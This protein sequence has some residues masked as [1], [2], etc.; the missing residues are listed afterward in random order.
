M[1]YKTMQEVVDSMKGIAEI[2]DKRVRVLNET[3]VRTDLI[4]K[5]VFNAV[6]NKDTELRNKIRWL[7][8]AI[9]H[10]LDA[11][12]ASIQ[13]LYD[14]MGRGEA[15]GFTVPAINIRGLTYDVARAV[16][17][18]AK[19]NNSG[20]FIFEIA[21]SE[22][23][24]TEQPPDEYAVV[25]IAA[26]VKEGYKGPV[27]IQGDH[28]QA[29]AKKYQ[30]DPAKEV[31]GL[32]ALIKEAIA[33]GFYNIDI[34][35]STLVD[36]S[37]PD[38]K[39]QQRLNFEIAAELTAYIRQLE[40]KGVTISVGGEIGEVGG[41]NSTV[42]ELRAFMNGYREAMAARGKSLQGISK[43]SVQTGTT[44]GGVPLPDGT[45]AKVKLDFDTLEKI[46]TAARQEYGLSGAVQHGASTLPDDAFH[47]FPETG[48]AE[49]HLATG[50]QN[51]TYDSKIFPADF[52]EDIYSHL[53]E[54]CADEKKQ[55]E[56]DEQF[57]YKT[58]KK[59]F[60][61]FKERF[62]TLPGPVKKTI[63]QELEDKLDFLFRKLKVVNTY[64][65]VTKYVTPAEEYPK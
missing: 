36:L 43:I 35:T 26:A 37:K 33:A 40:P 16:I 9:A 10:E 52:R 6:F 45:I 60:G 54:K 7:I 58:R 39:E 20:A 31:A 46:S 4:D 18:A 50:F 59:G 47:R 13:G 30:Q 65:I 14:A 38:T 57:I 34:D 5:L 53:R 62:W 21:K 12:S 11:I 29:N 61:P 28:F 49:V 1:S 22:I 42:G 51:M 56:S 24:Y 27:F 63:G 23:G 15:G 64:S 3:S 44:H 8:R 55:G 25:L 17:R 2:K 48:T 32:K 19:K 41:Q